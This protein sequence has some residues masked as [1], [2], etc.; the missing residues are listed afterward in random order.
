[1]KPW[2]TRTAKD[3][4]IVTVG[5]GLSTIFGALSIF[6][7]ARF[8]GTADFGIYV[9]ALAIAVIVTDSLELAISGSIVKFASRAD[10][11]AA[12]FIKY[13]F[14]LKLI[15]GLGL[16][17]VFWL[18]SRPLA[19]LLSSELIKPLAVAAWFIPVLFLTRFPRSLL[20]AGKQFLKD[21]SLEAGT[22]LFRLLAVI[23]FYLTG[24]L[25][26]NSALAAFLLGALVTFLIGSLMVSWKF[27]K[28]P[29]TTDTRNHF[30]SFQKWMTLAYVVAAIHG[31]IDNPLVL[32][33][34]SP[35]TSGLYQA[36][37]RFFMPALQLSAALS[38]V[39][40]PRFAS[41]PDL[42]TSRE[43]MLKA[44]RLTLALG[45]LVLTIIPFARMLV[46]LIF[47][48]DYAGSILPVQILSLGFVAFVAGAPFVAY[49]IYA[50]NQ[51]K[52]FLLVNLLQ[53]IL[54]VSLDFALVPK[55]GAIGAAT[56]TSAT[57][58]TVNLL[59]AALA[60]F[61]VKKKN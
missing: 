50:A 6:A 23:G 39:F 52:L 22:S 5:M 14:Y 13:G 59:M 15:L 53:L 18:L 7:I 1:M 43:Y 45:L 61:Y 44:S 57:L 35:E 55:L 34:S 21:T 25:T 20:Q 41:F 28:A 37:Y 29:I 27:L 2:Q 26:V 32:R 47:G 51:T 60:L 11:R 42:K 30:F 56:A 4:A 10:E 31:R 58:I 12:G 40:A 3:S 33:L 17:L 16:G 36:A 46:N 54:L 49:L 9:T 19:N 24:R 8:L 38:L 48:A